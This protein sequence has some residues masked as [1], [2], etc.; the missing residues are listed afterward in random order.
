[1]NVDAIKKTALCKYDDEDKVYVVE[2]PLCD[3]VMGADE[4]M[5]QAWEV[6][7]EILEETYEDYQAGKLAKSIGPGRPK[8]NKQNIN[9]QVTGD[10]KDK[11][12]ELAETLGISQ[13]DVLDY[14]VASIDSLKQNEASHEQI[15]QAVDRVTELMKRLEVIE[16]VVKGMASVRLH[17]VMLRD[18]GKSNTESS[19]ELC[20]A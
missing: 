13:G 18:H 10:T 16:S 11:I 3:F 17:P 14:L 2:S 9:V 20:Q 7:H 19:K 1:M 12:K 8:R 15:Q 4:D 5:H 6:F